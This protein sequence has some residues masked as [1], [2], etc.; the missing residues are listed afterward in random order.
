MT[1]QHMNYL[2][3][4]A[5]SGS[6]NKTTEKLF[7]SQPTLTSV[8]RDVESEIGISVFHRT[9]KGVI[10]TAE[11]EDFLI[12]IRKVWQQYD[13][14]LKNYEKGGKIRRK[15]AVSM[16]HYSF[17]VKAFIEMAK[18]YDSNQFDLVLRETKTADVIKDVSSLKS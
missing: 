4:I 3:T 11:G 18:H 15:F 2:L 6:M 14:M 13:E 17:A 5:E 7:I 12:R 16:Q 8:V 10:P 1:L 9:P